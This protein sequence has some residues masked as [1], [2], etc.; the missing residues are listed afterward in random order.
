MG[1]TSFG[2]VAVAEEGESKL[3]RW[4]VFLAQQ[5]HAEQPVFEENNLD[6]AQGVMD[7]LNAFKDSAS[8]TLREQEND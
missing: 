8:D 3:A 5:S 4:I 1:S 6:S 7:Q 2:L